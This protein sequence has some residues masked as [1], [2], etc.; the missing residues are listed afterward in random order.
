MKLSERR[1]EVTKA[2]LVANGIP[3]EKISVEPLGETQLL[4]AATVQALEAENPFKPAD[5]KQY[6]PRTI[7]LAYNRRVDIELQPAELQSSRFLPYATAEEEVLLK[8]SWPRWKTVNEAQQAP[9]VATIAGE[10]GQ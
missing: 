9:T 4:D 2:F 8:P 1:I 3:A 5:A 6:K 7:R 10:A